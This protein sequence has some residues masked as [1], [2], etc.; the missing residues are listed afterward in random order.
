MPY[1]RM[2]AM[3]SY[4]MLRVEHAEVLLVM[5]N[6]PDM[7]RF[8]RSWGRNTAPD[9]CGMLGYILKM[10]S[11]A[12]GL[13]VIHCRNVLEVEQFLRR[14]ALI[15]KRNHVKRDRQRAKLCI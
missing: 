3:P 6:V 13:K 2:H 1:S 14:V 4:W 10:L 15:A 5:Q 9:T 7:A 8:P 11:L 12:V